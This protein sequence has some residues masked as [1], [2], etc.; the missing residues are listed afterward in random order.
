MRTAL[1]LT[2]LALALSLG[3]GPALAGDPNSAPSAPRAPE[4]RLPAVQLPTPT[5]LPG[6]TGIAAFPQLPP[7]P[8]GG[9]T[10]LQ[11][12]GDETVDWI[13]GLTLILEGD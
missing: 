9:P 7:P 5:H 12:A 3:A 13:V 6:P 10:D 11:A 8:P 1:H 4:T 2:T